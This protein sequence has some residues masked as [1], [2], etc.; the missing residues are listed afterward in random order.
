MTI[1][2]GP[3]R[4]MVHGALAGALG[5]RA[6]IGH[7]SLPLLAVVRGPAFLALPLLKPSEAT[8]TIGGAQTSE[9]PTFLIALIIVGTIG[10]LLS[11]TL[12]FYAG[13]VWGERAI[14]RMHRQFRGRR[15][16][17]ILQRTTD[18]VSRGGGL[19]VVLA[20]P[21]VVAHGIAP[22]VAGASGFGT[23]RFL[24]LAACG[25]AL[26]AVIFTLGG[27]AAGQI[28]EALP[29]SATQR[30]TALSV[31]VAIALIVAIRQHRSRPP[32]EQPSPTP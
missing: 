14:Q 22:I 20:R 10:G 17:T 1:A 9:G 25:A 26:W 23:A 8:M 31:L 3:T 13:R 29:G 11:D 4:R 24:R 21:T 30:L 16:T 5:A 18:A 2:N 28:W 6:I 32:A 12:S 19:A 27:I 7:L 15:I